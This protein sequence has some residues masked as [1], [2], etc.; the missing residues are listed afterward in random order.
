MTASPHFCDSLDSYE[1]RTA[2]RM[3]RICWYERKPAV[4]RIWRLRNPDSFAR[5]VSSRHARKAPRDQ[6]RWRPTT[7]VIEGA[8]VSQ[9]NSLRV[10]DRRPATKTRS[11]R[12]RGGALACCCMRAHTQR[13][14][15]ACPAFL[16]SCGARMGPDARWRPPVDSL[17]DTRGDHSQPCGSG[18]Y[19]LPQT[20]SLSRL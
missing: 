14:E 6:R 16:S 5:S 17:V 8:Q 7:C 13:V 10:S 18:V 2:M 12:F 9:R 4:R 11:A 19:P 20:R 1:P 15:A 3:R